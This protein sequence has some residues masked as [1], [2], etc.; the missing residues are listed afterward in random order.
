MTFKIEG[1]IKALATKR[2]QITFDVTVGL[3]MAVQETLE[4]ERFLADPADKPVRFLL[5]C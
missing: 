3:K 4:V 1:V 2:A 5:G